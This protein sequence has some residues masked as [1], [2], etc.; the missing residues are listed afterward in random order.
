MSAKPAKSKD[1]N[2]FASINHEP[3]AAKIDPI[4]TAHG[5]ERTFGGL[6]AVDVNHL[7]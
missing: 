2:P 5:I 6:K 3:G 1:N 7:V 4:I